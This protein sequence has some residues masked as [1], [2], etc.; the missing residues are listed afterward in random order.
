MPGG[1]APVPE[2]QNG[3]LVVA[4]TANT[5]SAY[6]VR[7]LPTE[8]QLGASTREEAVRVARSFAA[9]KHVDVWLQDGREWRLLAHYRR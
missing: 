8:A 9:A 1:A 3:D 7:Q 2:P 6:G 5:T 4:R